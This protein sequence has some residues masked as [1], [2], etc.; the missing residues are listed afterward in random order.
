[1]R[2]QGKMQDLPQ[3]ASH[4]RAHAPQ[5]QLAKSGHPH[6]G[7]TAPD[8]NHE[9]ETPP[10]QEKCTREGLN[11]HHA[12]DRATRTPRDQQSDYG[13]PKALNSE[14]EERGGE[15]RPAVAVTGAPQGAVGAAVVAPPV[16]ARA[17]ET[18]AELME[19]TRRPE[20]AERR[21]LRWRNPRQRNRRQRR[22]LRRRRRLKLRRL[23]G[24]RRQRRTRQTL[25]WVQLGLRVGW[26]QRRRRRHCTA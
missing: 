4:R 9:R 18:E 12:G 14:E 2:L 8:A 19:D 3:G 23:R 13:V 26:R 16:V 1:M 25:R 22:R 21:P 17:A 10:Q 5:L 11:H 7:K 20:T 6:N 15:K 24:G